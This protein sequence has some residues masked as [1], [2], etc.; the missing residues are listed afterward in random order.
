MYLT[1]DSCY[2]NGGNK[3]HVESPET[4]RDSYLEHEWVVRF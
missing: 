3:D 2:V 1:F 4:A